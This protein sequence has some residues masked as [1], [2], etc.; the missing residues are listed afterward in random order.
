MESNAVKNGATAMQ[1]Q[2][3]ANAEL[4]KVLQALVVF[5]I[6]CQWSVTKVVAHLRA[7]RE[8]ANAA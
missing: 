8:K 5:F 1:I 7:K 6:A 3:G 4:V 2:A